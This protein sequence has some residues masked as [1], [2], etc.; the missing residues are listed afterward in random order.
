[1][2][3]TEQTANHTPQSPNELTGEQSTS[4]QGK[5]LA[6]IRSVEPFFY[7]DVGSKWVYRRYD[8]VAEVESEVIQQVEEIKKGATIDVAIEVFTVELEEPAVEVWILDGNKVH[9]NIPSISDQI[10]L[11]KPDL[12]R[13]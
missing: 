1:M 4:E 6:E 13:F 3:R 5:S 11:L 9:R 2:S 8:R 12:R 10:R 7:F